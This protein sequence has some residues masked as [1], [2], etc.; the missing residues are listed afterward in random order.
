M[1][2]EGRDR[3]GSPSA[4]IP[5]PMTTLEYEL[6][7]KFIEDRCGLYFT[8]TRSRF[9]HQRLWERMRICGY[10]SYSEYYHHVAFNP[11]GADEWK[12]ILE[13]LLNNET[14]FFRHQPSFDALTELVLPELLRAKQRHGVNI[15]TMWS[16]GCSTGQEAYSLA[17]A[18][19]DLI[20]GQGASPPREPLPNAPTNGKGPQGWRVMVSGTDLDALAL[21]RAHSA[22]YTASQVRYMPE[23]YRDRYLK[24]TAHDQTGASQ[25]QVVEPVR[26]LTQFGRLNLSD[27][28]SYWV[29]AQD[30]IF[31]QNV[32]LYFRPESRI[33]VVQRLCQ[34]LNPGGYLF[35]APAEVVGLKLPNIQLV[36][37]PN[38]LIYQRQEQAK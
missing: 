19:L 30:I 12:Q 36:R 3:P 1:G 20:S 27:S 37:H 29:S 5:A 33:Q 28:A 38:V 18:F 15:I 11:K 21:E 16:A 22:Q 9:L 14:G 7:S 34:R 31:C 24:V 25:Y 10:K 2:N 26:V 8:E 32:L 35:L 4:P 23:Y 6:W 17:M 13:L